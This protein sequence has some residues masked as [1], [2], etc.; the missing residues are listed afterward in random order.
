MPRIAFLPLLIL[1][2]EHFFFI[3]VIIVLI[4]Y[5]IFLQLQLSK[6]NIFLN[7][8]F[9]AI[10]RSGK[11]WDKEDVLKLIT[12]LQQS[13]PAKKVKKDYFRQNNFIMLFF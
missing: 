3:G 4:I 11:N 2:G 9:S 10:K 7:S 12:K 13:E 8:I 6:R 1:Q 5:I